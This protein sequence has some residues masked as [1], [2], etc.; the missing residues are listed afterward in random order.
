MTIVAYYLLDDGYMAI[1]SVEF[2]VE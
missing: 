2:D 1:A